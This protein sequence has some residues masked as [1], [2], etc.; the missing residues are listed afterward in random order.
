MSAWHGGLCRE[1]GGQKSLIT[2][3]TSAW[4]SG[5]CRE[6]EGGRRV[7]LHI[8]RVLGIVDCVGRERGAEES[9]YI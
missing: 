1:R 7:L 8:I 6:R 9:Y 2:Y 5:L 4:H 3:N